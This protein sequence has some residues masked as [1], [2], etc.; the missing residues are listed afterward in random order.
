MFS[1]GFCSLSRWTLDVPWPF[2]KYIIAHCM[3]TGVIGIL[4]ETASDSVKTTDFGLFDV[5]LPP[6]PSWGP[7]GDSCGVDGLQEVRNGTDQASQ[8]KKN[9]SKCP[10]WT[11]QSRY[12]RARRSGY[13]REDAGEWENMQI[14]FNFTIHPLQTNFCAIR[15]SLKHFSGLICQYLMFGLV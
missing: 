8:A 12:S 1:C 14:M 10:S 7:W 2:P 13:F 11:S 5:H 9:Y 6:P 15:L 4:W 3:A